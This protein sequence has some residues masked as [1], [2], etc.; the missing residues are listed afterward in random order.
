MPHIKNLLAA[1]PLFFIALFYSF[2][3][4]VLFF[5]PTT[6]LPMVSFLSADKLI[7]LV[8][9][10]ILINLWLIYFY[11]KN[12]FIFEFKWTVILFFFILLYGIIIEIFKGLFTASRSADIFDLIANLM[13]TILGII[14]F[15]KI[16]HHINI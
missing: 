6:E 14:F 5:M 11:I 3:I 15:K 8:I 2:V 12:N 9:Y 16:K 7:H 1:K 10:F 4:S 13:G